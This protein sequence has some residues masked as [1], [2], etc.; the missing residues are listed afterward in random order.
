MFAKLLSRFWWMIMIRGVLAV[1]F[2]IILFAWPGVSLASLMLIFGIFALADGFGNVVNAIGGRREHENWWVLLVAG[3]AGMALGVLT[4]A[5]PGGTALVILFYIAIWVIATGLLQIVT[6]IRLR[7]EIE[8][9]FW[10][11]LGGLVSVAVGI[12]LVARPV[13]GVLAIIWLIAAYA[14]VFGALQIMLALKA[15]GFAK[16]IKSATAA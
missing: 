7:K 4:L 5:N 13:E 11:M 15:R 14:I 10:M 8:G 12:A 16:R 3:L 1:A 9:E 6:A 2:G